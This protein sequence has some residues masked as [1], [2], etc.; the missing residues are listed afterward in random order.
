MD[1]GIVEVAVAPSLGRVMQFGFIGS[2][3]VFWENPALTGRPMPE[4]PWSAAMGSFGGDKTW[5][6][7]QGLWNWP[8]PDVFDRTALEARTEG[9]DTVVLTSAVSARFGI[10]TERRIT[11]DPQAAVL[12]IRT[13]YTKVQGPPTECA[14]WIITQLRD[15]ER[16]F[17][18]IPKGSR[19]ASGWSEQWKMPSNLVTVR[20]GLVS[21]RRETKG[22]Y[23]VGNDGTSL[24][25]MGA[26][27][28]LRID[29]ER[30]A[31]AAYPDEGCSVEAYT[32]P[33]PVPYV[34][35]E[36]LAPLRKLEAGQSMT[37]TNV[38]R[39]FR[40]TGGDVW[41]EARTLLAGR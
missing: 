17:L 37:A 11:L 9:G 26:T 20:D 2:E 27:E 40:R 25:W 35:L 41:A 33:D 23:K 22:S 32:N 7:P 29:V 15:P 21:V 6:A 19:F 13:T 5:P 1:N 16:V 12:R 34:E 31:G 4:D 3:G 8:P 10:R 24:L 18:P 39:L 30:V 28:A 38:Y 36:T 14:V